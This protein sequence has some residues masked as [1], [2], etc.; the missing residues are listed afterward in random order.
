MVWTR[1]TTSRRS[2]PMTVSCP[3]AA[4]KSSPSKGTIPVPA[5]SIQARTVDDTSQRPSRMQ[6]PDLILTSRPASIRTGKICNLV[7]FCVT[8]VKDYRSLS[9]LR[10]CWDKK[11]VSKYPDNRIIQYKFPVVCRSWDIDLVSQQAAFR[12]IRHR[13]NERPL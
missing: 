3:A 8:P 9:L 10:Y 12:I 11:N 2:V 6:S 5:R 1:K 4:S 13:N 7:S